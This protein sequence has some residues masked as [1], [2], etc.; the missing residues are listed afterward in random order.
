[1]EDTGFEALLKRHP[2]PWKA[3][4]PNYVTTFTAT[5]RDANGDVVSNTISFAADLFEK[6]PEM[7]MLLNEMY[8]SIHDFGTRS[9]TKTDCEDRLDAIIE[10][11]LTDR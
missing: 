7:F 6:A 10:S 1:M 5:L 11:S 9:H 8:S 3:Y 2:L 4:L